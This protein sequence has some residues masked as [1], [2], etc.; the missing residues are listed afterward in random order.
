MQMSSLTLISH[1]D[2]NSWHTR[3]RMMHCLSYR[4][5]IGPNLN[6]VLKLAHTQNRKITYISRR[7]S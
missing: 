2:K 6:Q 1:L 5:S 7:S 4:A 3:E